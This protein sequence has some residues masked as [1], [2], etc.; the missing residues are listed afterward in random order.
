MFS[1]VHHKAYL[2]SGNAV[3][4]NSWQRQ[5]N[6]AFNEARNIILN[7]LP[8]YQS[9]KVLKIRNTYNLQT[10]TIMFVHYK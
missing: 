8:T 10:I 5:S 3:L 6:N 4:N 7:S 1:V 2:R 9:N